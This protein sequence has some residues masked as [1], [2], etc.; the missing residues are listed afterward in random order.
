MS[1]KKHHESPWKE[2]KERHT[3]LQI[4]NNGYPMLSVVFYEKQPDNVIIEPVPNT[5]NNPRWHFKQ[6]QWIEG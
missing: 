5:L 2:R 4:D 1:Q 3:G 6:K